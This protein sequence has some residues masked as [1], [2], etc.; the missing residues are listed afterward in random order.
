MRDVDT[1]EDEFATIALGKTVAFFLYSLIGILVAS[2]VSIVFIDHYY[3]PANRKLLFFTVTGVVELII[4]WLVIRGALPG[5][6]GDHSIPFS[7]K[8]AAKV[9]S[10]LSFLPYLLLI[11][12]PDLFILASWY[13]NGLLF[14]IVSVFFVAKSFVSSRIRFDVLNVAMLPLLHII[15]A[16]QL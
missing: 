16:S 1:S 2:A 11:R 4:L 7:E 15:V 9:L 14:L 8:T 5:T 6:S 10:V 13:L 3:E 12:I